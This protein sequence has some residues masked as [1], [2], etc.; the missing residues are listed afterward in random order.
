MKAKCNCHFCNMNEIRV[1]SAALTP[2]VQGLFPGHQVECT[3]CA[4]RGP[5]GYID[6]RNA[7]AAWERGEHLLPKPSIV[8]D[9][10][11]DRLNTALV[12]ETERAIKQ[13]DEFLRTGIVTAGNGGSHDTCFAAIVRRFIAELN[14][15]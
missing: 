5:S 15:Q 2:E 13:R 8:P 6:E 14:P 12:L 1:L 4:A 7:I 10:W 3:N 9:G 11:E